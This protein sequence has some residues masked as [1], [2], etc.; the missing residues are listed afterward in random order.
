MVFHS[1]HSENIF[2]VSFGQYRTYE[3]LKKLN[4]NNNNLKSASVSKRKR[5]FSLLRPPASAQVGIPDDGTLVESGVEVKDDIR[6]FDEVDVESASEKKNTFL[7][8][9]IDR[10]PSRCNSRCHVCHC[11]NDNKA[12]YLSIHLSID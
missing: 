6:S 12:I 4:N 7:W 10:H 8:S 3:D 9:L 2:K 1:G 11:C 5:S